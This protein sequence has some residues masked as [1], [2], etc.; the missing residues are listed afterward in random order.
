MGKRFPAA[1]LTVQ[2]EVSDKLDILV[3]NVFGESRQSRVTAGTFCGSP[4]VDIFLPAFHFSQMKNSFWTGYFHHI[5]AYTA[6]YV[7]DP[8]ITHRNA[9][10]R[11]IIK[12]R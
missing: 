7:R 1:L 12:R 6:T 8:A 5:N 11:V 2:R 10:V 4:V 3:Q 9:R